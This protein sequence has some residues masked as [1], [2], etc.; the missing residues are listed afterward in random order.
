MEKHED[1]ELARRLDD[2]KKNIADLKSNIKTIDYEQEK[3]EKKLKNAKELEW[4]VL[5]SFNKESIG[6]DIY[7]SLEDISEADKNI[8]LSLEDKMADCK[9][10]IRKLM[11]QEETLKKKIEEREN[12]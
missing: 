8:K 6:D 4:D 5:H 7:R 9:H 12:D 11:D 1:L 3:F 2:I 10:A